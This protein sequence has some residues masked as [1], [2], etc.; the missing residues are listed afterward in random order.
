MGSESTNLGSEGRIL[1][2]TIGLETEYALL[3]VR[4]GRD[5][6]DES[7]HQLPEDWYARLIAAMAKHSVLVRGL[8]NSSRFFNAQGGSI[9]RELR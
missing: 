3:L 8:G 9:S 2:R 7:S 4:K 5:L 6:D 1:A